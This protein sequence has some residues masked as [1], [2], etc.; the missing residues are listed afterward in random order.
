MLRLTWRSA[1]AAAG[2][3]GPFTDELAHPVLLLA[4]DPRG[5]FRTHYANWPAP[6]FATCRASEF[7]KA[8]SRPVDGNQH[9]VVALPWIADM[10]L[11][12]KPRERLTRTTM[13]ACL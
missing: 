13:S 1:T 7:C 5:A 10:H 11:V 6:F 9:H 8:S 12:R 2:N 4:D 3:S